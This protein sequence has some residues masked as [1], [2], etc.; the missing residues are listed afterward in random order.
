M[1]TTA[2]YLTAMRLATEN[3]QALLIRLIR[4]RI[5]KASKVSGAGRSCMLTWATPDLDIRNQHVSW[6][7]DQS[8]IA[9]HSEGQKGC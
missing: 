4:L 3:L 5:C 8:C 2:K 1:L 7:P 9:G 6:T